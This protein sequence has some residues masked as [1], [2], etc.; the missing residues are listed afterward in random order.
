MASVRTESIKGVSAGKAGSVESNGCP[1][2][3]SRRREHHDEA[4]AKTAA[5]AAGG[6]ILGAA[7]GGGSGAIIGGAVS[8]AVICA[9]RYLDKRGGSRGNG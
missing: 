5:S 4:V 1:M 8:V 6:A 3:R 2:E 9:A 7:I